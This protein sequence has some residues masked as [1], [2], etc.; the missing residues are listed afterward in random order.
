MRCRMRSLGVA[1]VTSRRLRRWACAALVAAVVLP[2]SG[3][4]PLEVI[5]NVP[6]MLISGQRG[7]ESMTVEGFGSIRKVAYAAVLSNDFISIDLPLFGSWF[8]REVVRLW[9]EFP[10]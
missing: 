5:G 3:W 8:H 6:L 4:G 10:L 1:V 2:L 9:N 7:S